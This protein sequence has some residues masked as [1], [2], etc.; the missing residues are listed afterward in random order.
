MESS[1]IPKN[2][3]Y[4]MQDVRLGTSIEMEHTRDRHVARGI[5]VQHLNEHFRYYRVLP[6]AEQF[7][8]VIENKPLPKPRHRKRAM[9]I[10]QWQTVPPNW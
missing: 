1:K 9:P 8:G 2:A 4:S 6:M 7:M 10:P 5:A 3:K